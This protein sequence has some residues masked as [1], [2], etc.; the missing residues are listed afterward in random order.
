MTV[1]GLDM[2]GY[3]DEGA[4][5]GVVTWDDPQYREAINDGLLPALKDHGQQLATPPYYITEAQT[6]QDFEMLAV[7]DAVESLAA[8]LS[9]TLDETERTLFEQALDVYYAA[10]DLTREGEHPEILLHLEAMRQAY[11][12]SYGRPIP[13]RDRREDAYR[14]MEKARKRQ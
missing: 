1:D 8:E 2:H 3:F 4:K 13:P 12:Q 9:A 6:L 5:I 7:A 11:E 14:D 10:E